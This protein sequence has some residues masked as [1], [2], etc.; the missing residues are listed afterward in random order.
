MET[1]R[2]VRQAQYDMNRRAPDA[3]EWYAPH[4]RRLMDELAQASGDLCVFGA[5]NCADIG[6]GNSLAPLPVKKHRHRH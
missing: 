5:G 1:A 4:R 2:R 6:K 3:S